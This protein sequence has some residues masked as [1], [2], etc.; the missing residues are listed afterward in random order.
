MTSLNA[1]LLTIFAFGIGCAIGRLRGGSWAGIS[2]AQFRRPGLLVLGLTTVFVLN[3]I[4]PA[5]PLLWAIVGTLAF[6][7]F[8]LRNLQ[9][10]GM[11][12]MLIG[13]LMNT[14]P[15]LSNGAVP[16]SELALISVGEVDESGRAQ[17]DGLRESTDTATAFAAFGDVIPVPVVNSVVS[18]GDIVMLV[19]LA[20]IA[21]NLFLRAR[22]RDELDDAG[23]TFASDAD[24]EVDRDGDA[25]PAIL[26][27]LSLG[28]SSRP[29]HAAH[30]RPR[31]KAAPSTH[32]PAHAKQSDFFD[33][34]DPDTVIVLDG[35][36]G[37]VESGVAKS[38]VPDVAP[39]VEEIIPGKV[40]MPKT[41]IILP[42]EADQPTPAHAKAKPKTATPAAQPEKPAPESP[43]A[44]SNEPAQGER[45]SRSDLES[46]VATSTGSVDNKTAAPNHAINSATPAAQ[47][48]EPALRE[49]SS[50]SDQ[51]GRRGTSSGSLD[52]KAEFADRRPI[53]DLTVSPT[54][55]QL[56]EFLRRRA[57]ADAALLARTSP[58]P[59]RRRGR[60]P[61]RSAEVADLAR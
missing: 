3:L 21:T 45:S 2:S 18:I 22:R 61:R 11:I 28:V 33:L 6:A 56:Q 25:R 47:P 34:T 23:V 14:A 60:A 36:D 41:E 48:D 31:R 15:L 12:I 9:L 42:E 52:N 51:V 7:V 13:L 32:V 10:S 37:Y 35:A 44:Q 27:P 24:V 26:S 54:D 57:E 50:R 19:A 16:V 49:R 30:R 40:E 55:D 8:G 4:G 5:F 29:A 59:R 38:K 58:G 17:I 39:P 43:A 53:I 46:K 20:D 1:V